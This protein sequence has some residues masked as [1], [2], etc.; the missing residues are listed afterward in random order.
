L[1]QRKLKKL[2]DF[3]SEQDVYPSVHLLPEVKSEGEKAEAEALDDLDSMFEDAA[4]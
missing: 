1:K 3:I 2:F 4:E